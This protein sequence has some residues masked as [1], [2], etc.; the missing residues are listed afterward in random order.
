ME[1]LAACHLHSKWSYDG[2][3]AL[4]DLA[5]AFAERGC[6]V[7]M[8]TEHDRGFSANK[9]AEFRDACAAVTTERMLVVPGM[10]YS[11]PANRVHVLVWGAPFLG[12]DLDT[13]VMLEAASRHR[14]VAVLAHPAR[15]RMW[16]CFRPEWTP[17]LLGIEAWNR[18]YDG[19]APSSV[20]ASLLATER[21]VP[22][23]GLDFHTRRQFFPLTMALT[24]D[25]AIDEASV[26]D[27]LRAGRCEARAFGKPLNA[28]GVQDALPVLRGAERG[29]RMLATLKRRARLFT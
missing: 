6:R 19:W 1:V 10:E 22:F 17:H 26:V 3:W 14:A 9:Y 28:R 13:G 29:R 16:E 21:R 20:G 24:L 2:S 27:S 4:E 15:M 12:A 7:L 18:K 11:D 8:M 25:G 23:V 5:A